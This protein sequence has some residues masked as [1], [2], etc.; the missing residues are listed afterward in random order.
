MV[1][2]R[3]SDG[4]RTSQVVRSTTFPSFKHSSQFAVIS[5]H[6][7]YICYFQ[8][9]YSD[10]SRDLVVSREAAVEVWVDRV[11]CPHIKTDQAEQATEV[12]NFPPIF[13]VVILTFSST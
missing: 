10:C 1:E 7:I 4:G 3:K 6:N 8:I 5:F 11:T 13:K 2:P 9:N 12:V